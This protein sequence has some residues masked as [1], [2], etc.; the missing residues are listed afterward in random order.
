MRFFPKKSL[1]AVVSMFLLCSCAKSQLTVAD[2]IRPPSQILRFRDIQTI[3]IQKPTITFSDKSMESHFVE[4]YQQTIQESFAKGFSHKPWYQIRLSCFNEDKS[5][6]F[7]EQISKKGFEWV[8]PV[9]SQIEASGQHLMFSNANIITSSEKDSGINMRASFSI[10]ILDAKGKEVYVQLFHNLEANDLKSTEG[11]MDKIC[12][13][14]RLAKKLFQPAINKVVNE[15]Y[16]KTIKQIISIHDNADIRGR[17]LLDAKAF[18]EALAHIKQSIKEKERLYIQ[19]KNKILREYTQIE[20]Q[21]KDRN[22]PDE[23]IR[24]QRIELAK[25]KE[26]KI[27][28]ARKILSGDYNNYGTALEALG[29]VDQSIEYYEKA[30]MADPFNYMARLAF[31]RLIYFRKTNNQELELDRENIEQS[32]RRQ[33]ESL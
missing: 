2:F 32:L 28:R 24:E 10:V 27:D 7:F 22:T 23:D 13:H 19:Q 15:I 12:M 11:H 30:F 5:D 18:P 4:L 25:E 6:S 16:P 8:N 26:K 21:L 9:P 31:H 14:Q 1:I 33:D 20:K 3:H 29:F 17:F